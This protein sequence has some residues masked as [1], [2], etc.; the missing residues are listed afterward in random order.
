MEASELEVDQGW[1]QNS[2]AWNMELSTDSKTNQ[3]FL[4]NS[5]ASV[6]GSAMSRVYSKTSEGVVYWTVLPCHSLSIGLSCL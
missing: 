3:F 5:S 4:K 2:K 6:M 1:L